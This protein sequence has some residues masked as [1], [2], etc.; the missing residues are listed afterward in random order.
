MKT[1]DHLKESKCLSDRQNLKMKV[2]FLSLSENEIAAEKEFYLGD[3]PWLGQSSDTRDDVT[4]VNKLL[5]TCSRTQSSVGRRLFRSQGGTNA[6]PMLISHAFGGFCLMLGNEENTGVGR[7][8]HSVDLILQIFHP[9]F[10]VDVQLSIE[11]VLYKYVYIHEKEESLKLIR[12][13]IKPKILFDNF[14]S[15]PT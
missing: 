8:W 9:M 14:H 4:D 3:C 1:F 10:I 6:W 11:S 15:L 7:I 13:L 12:S 2:A 5:L